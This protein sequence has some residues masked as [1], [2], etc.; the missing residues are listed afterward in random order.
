MKAYTL[1]QSGELEGGASEKRIQKLLLQT[2]LAEFIKIRQTTD[3]LK[4]QQN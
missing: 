1:I 2:A 4:S 3:Q